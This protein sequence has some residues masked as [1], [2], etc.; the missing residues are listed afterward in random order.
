M[1][2]KL[3]V[4][5]IVASSAWAEG[6]VGCLSR[7]R[8]GMTN[9]LN[10]INTVEVANATTGT[11]CSQ[12]VFDVRSQRDLNQLIGCTILDGHLRIA[13]Y[14]D[15]E[16]D[17]GQIQQIKGDLIVKNASELIKINGASLES[18]TGDMHL[19]GLTSIQ[20]ITL[21]RLSRAGSIEWDVLPLL[22]NVEVSDF[23]DGLNKLIVS[24][25]S[26]TSFEGFGTEELSVLKIHNNRYLEKVSLGVKTVANELSIAG[27]SDEMDISLKNL[28]HAQDVT[29]RD[30]NSIE[31]DSLQEIGSTAGFINNHFS[32]LKLPKLKSVG[33]TLSISENSKLTQIELKEVTEIDGGLVI[34][35][36]PRVTKVD[37]L[38]KLMVVGGAVELVG[39]F[40]EASFSSLK[41]VKGSSIVNT[42][43]N[44]FD[45]NKWTKSD[46][47]RVVRGGKIECSAASKS[48]QILHVDKDGA[49][50]QEKSQS[51]S[52]DGG[53]SVT[54]ESG[55]MRLA[56]SSLVVSLFVFLC[57]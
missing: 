4:L 54:S 15:H 35:K 41:L 17:L 8:N 11:V 23:V 43:S 38:P 19:A 55:A 21:P 22:A 44:R 26:L 9:H 10:V 46:A 25:T 49:V 34:V 36:N 30:V 13:D 7:N 29:V 6:S 40:D 53:N 51:S 1:F 57:C 18:I 33:G 31:L 20:T 16:A 12:N 2:L 52:S 3:I 32:S 56:P 28:S 50:T 39:Q 14:E 42:K 24:D 5:V 47:R 27:N 45:C 48:T 37:F